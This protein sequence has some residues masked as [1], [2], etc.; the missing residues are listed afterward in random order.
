LKKNKFIFAIALIGSLLISMVN[1]SVYAATGYEGYAVYR[2]G[3][4]FNY[5]WHAAIMD[6]A[7]STT[8]TRP[9]VHSTL[10]NIVNYDTWNNF[11][12]GKT[13]KGV[14]RPN[15]TPTS[16][17]RDLF[18]SMGRKLANE[19]ISYNAGYQVYYNTSTAG[20]WVDSSEISSMR[21]DG[22]VEYIYEWYGFKVYGNST[23]WDVTKNSFWGRDHHSG[24]AVTPQ[25]QAGYLTLVTS[26]I[27]K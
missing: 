7:Y 14:Y 9:I 5:T 17:D 10:G 24:T 3:V 25:S 13:F 2:D 6:E 12:N 27:P 16:T 23:Y 19:N 15:I 18:K 21:C 26:S 11:L 8:T 22:V 4:L 1:S 20:T